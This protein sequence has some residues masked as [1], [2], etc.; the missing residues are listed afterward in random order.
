M[1]VFLFVG[2]GASAELGVPTMRPMASELLDHLRRTRAATAILDTLEANLADSNYDIESIID[3]L[4]RLTGAQQVLARYAAQSVDEVVISAARE[5]LAETEWFVQHSCERARADDAALMWGPALEAALSL[6]KLVVASTNYDR[7]VELAAL[8][9]DIPIADGFNA[10]GTREWA[11]WT[12]QFPTA[13]LELLK[14]HGSTDWFRVV[15]SDA[16]IKLKHAMPLF[17]DIALELVGDDTPGRVSGGLVLPSREKLKNVAPFVDLSARMYASI[18]SADVTVFLGSSFRDPDVQHLCS[19]AVA[20]GCRVLAI[21]PDLET[22][23]TGPVP[24]GAVIFHQTASRFLISTFPQLISKEFNDIAVDDDEPHG[25][26]M[27]VSR[28]LD[29]AAPPTDR[30]RAIEDLWRR[31]V[32]LPTAI[33]MKLIRSSANSVATDALG[34]V[35]LAWDRSQLL[36]SCD[37]LASE[38]PESAFAAEVLLLRSLVEQPPD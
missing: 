14:I 27:A 31:R 17:G 5:A 30:C 3:D 4:E 13:G 33:L 38:Q 11:Q 1:N 22:A 23:P 28:A 2:A 6:S 26:L 20:R 12:G 16:V 32:P 36:E 37:L 34:L 8:S 18:E 25:V 29:E 15:E 19:L 24:T 35:P 9:H 10:F 21:G 7:A